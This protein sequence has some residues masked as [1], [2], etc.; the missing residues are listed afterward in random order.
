M[1]SSRYLILS[2]FPLIFLNVFAIVTAQEWLISSTRL[3]FY[4]LFILIY[5]RKFHSFQL[6]LTAFFI[7]YLAGEISSLYKEYW[8]LDVVSMT[9]FVTAYIFLCREA[10]KHT[11]RESA[12]RYMVIYFVLILLLN[13]YFLLLHVLEL[14]NYIAGY[15]RYALYLLYYVNVL[16]L[17]IVGLVY[18]LNSYS[19]KAVF[20][21]S[22]VL[23]LIFADI[24][25]DMDTFYAKDMGVLILENLLR[26]SSLILAYLF[27]KTRERKLRLLHMI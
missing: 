5:L 22:L 8:Y 19:R 18:Y 14:Q 7:F 21:I 27:F 2:S 25:R 20:F 24:F 23:V 12:S 4:V 6:N 17:G 3:L 1:K 26:F 15:L 10:I 16:V 9:F 13:A 11:E